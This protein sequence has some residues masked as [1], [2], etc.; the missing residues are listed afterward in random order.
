MG[1][2]GTNLK[3]ITHS[4]EILYLFNINYVEQLEYDN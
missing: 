3:C 2:Y 1:D 4:I